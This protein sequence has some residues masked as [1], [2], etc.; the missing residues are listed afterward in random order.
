MVQGDKRKGPRKP[1]QGAKRQRVSSPVAIPRNTAYYS[2][3]ML[4]EMKGMDTDIS[5]SPIVGTLNTNEGIYPLNLIQPGT[6]SWNRVGRKVLLQS[7]RVVGRLYCSIRPDPAGVIRNNNVRLLLVWDKQPSGAALPAFNTVF[8]ITSQGGVE[9]CPDYTSPPR[10]DNMSR[11]KVLKDWNV[12][13]KAEFINPTG[14]TPD[15]K[16]I[17]IVDTYVKL[18]GLET[19][20]SG[21]S[22]PCTI[23]DISSGALYLIQRAHTDTASVST[24]ESNMVA[25]LRYVE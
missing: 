22:N 4:P 13:L 2:R 1:K 16:A 3:A 6:G 7:I 21:Q 9:S 24:V 11:F 14:A 5:Y 19:V 17:G 18:K 25:R 20:F 12:D 23:A 15:Y 8:G 10:Y